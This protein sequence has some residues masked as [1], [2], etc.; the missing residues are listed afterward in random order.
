MGYKE[1]TEQWTEHE[2]QFAGLLESLTKTIEGN[3]AETEKATAELKLASLE[4]KSQKSKARVHYHKFTRGKDLSRY[5]QKDLAN[6][7]GKKTLNEKQEQNQEPSDVIKT[8]ERNTGVQMLNSGSMVDY[9]KRK[10]PAFGQSNGYTVGNNG[11]LTKTYD[12]DEQKVKK[13]KRTVGDKEECKKRE[14]ND[15]GITNPAF[16][17]LHTNLNLQKRTLNTIEESDSENFLSEDKSEGGETEIIEDVAVVSEIQNKKKKK[18]KKNRSKSEGLENPCFGEDVNEE[19]N[20]YE[21][22]NKQ[23]K[24]SKKNKNKSQGLENPCFKDGQ[25]EE[26][27]L[28]IRNIAFDPEINPAEAHK[29]NRQL[30]N[31]DTADSKINKSKKKRKLVEQDNGTSA[32]ENPYEIP[33]K[34]K[35]KSKKDTFAL[36][37]PNFSYTDESTVAESLAESMIN[38]ELAAESFEV[39]RKAKKSKKKKNTEEGL[40]NPALNLNNSS[41]PQMEIVEQDVNCDIMLNVS[42]TP[43]KSALKP[44]QSSEN[45]KSKC[46][47]RR[48]SVHFSETAQERV[49][50]NGKEADNRNELF[51][52]N[53]KIITK[54]IEEQTESGGPQVSFDLKSIDN[55]NF[56]DDGFTK[57][58]KRGIQN[59]AF[60]SAGASL[61]ENVGAIRKTIEN[62]QVE[63]ENGMNEAKYKKK[64]AIVNK[65]QQCQ[66]PI[67]EIGSDGENEGLEEGS[68]LRFKHAKFSKKIPPWANKRSEQGAKKTYKHLIRGDII[69]QFKNANLHEIEGYAYGKSCADIQTNH[70]Y[71]DNSQFNGNGALQ[72][73]PVSKP[74]NNS[75]NRSRP[76]GFGARRYNRRIYSRRM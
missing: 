46:L 42:C 44:Y 4:A 3:T 74:Y 31:D 34:K 64:F 45:G 66:R 41:S 30:F 61:E 57:K 75:P 55:I 22:Q 72:P 47:R 7:F 20:K 43:V 17:P 71:F 68:K 2:E 48:K 60:D 16:D 35:K 54:S 37:N 23:S 40:D 62:Y 12:N 58:G 18:E 27:E 28:G 59:V 49:I 36:D 13:K 51:D 76:G 29:I 56:Y 11:V 63:V 8:D 5:S 67:G 70:N 50:Q 65:Y 38:A 52:I 21:S 53:T 19:E 73:A 69:V 33:T 9:F 10:L 1:Q 6:I 26:G 39:K 25:L 14:M 15:S 24:K 32:F